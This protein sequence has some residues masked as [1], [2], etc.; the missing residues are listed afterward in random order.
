MPPASRTERPA[1]RA[2]RGLRWTRLA[3]HALHGAL[4][5]RFLFPRA[6]AARRRAYVRWWSE[7]LVSVAGV[8]LQVEGELPRPGENAVMVAANHISW[9]DMF[10]VSAAWPTRFVAKSEVRD[11]PLAGWIAERAG[12]LFIR[13]DR[14]RDTARMNDQVHAVLARRDCVGF[15]PEGTTS[16]GDTLL[17]FHTSLFEPA[18]ANAAHLH[19]VAIRYEHRDGAPA[20]EVAY[21][22][23]LSFM[24]SMARV[25]AQ[26][27]VVARVMFG[28]PIDCAQVKDRREAAH[29]ARTRIANLLALEL[30]DNPPGIRAGLRAAPP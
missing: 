14:R 9:L 26:R 5:L 17:K 1:G 16:E 20:P 19:P 29:L 25:V 6:D 8:A 11:W 27:G 15:F 3:L 7:K 2:L 10:A 21:V 24:Q 12:T 18:V 30:A 4:I 13:R 22:G 28:P 23:E